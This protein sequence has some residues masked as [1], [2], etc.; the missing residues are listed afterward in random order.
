ML[1]VVAVL[2]VSVVELAVDVVNVMDVMV[3]VDEVDVT[4]VVDDHDVVELLVCDWVVDSSAPPSVR[5][6]NAALQLHSIT[7]GSGLHD[8]IVFVC[9]VVVSEVADENVYVEVV[10]DVVKLDVRLV[11]LNE[12][13]V[14]LVMVVVSVTVTKVLTV[15]VDVVVG[16]DTV[17]KA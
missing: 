11:K 14:V 1:D 10:V 2:V 8:G 7:C 4:D 12:V 16:V 13:S 9:V 6:S 15:V 17:T 3:V 5:F